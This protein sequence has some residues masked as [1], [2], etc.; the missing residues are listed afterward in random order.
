MYGFHQT[1]KIRQATRHIS[2]GQ[3][4]ELPR[5]HFLPINEV[6]FLVPLGALRLGTPYLWGGFLLRCFQ[7]LSHPDLATRRCT[8]RHNRNTSGPFD[9]VL[10]Y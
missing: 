3:L 5:F 9:S 10:S 1:M 6:V 4:H 8:W 7:R 2:T